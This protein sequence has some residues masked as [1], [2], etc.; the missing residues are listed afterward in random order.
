MTIPL[1]VLRLHAAHAFE[2]GGFDDGAQINTFYPAARML[3]PI[4]APTCEILPDT[5]ATSW[6]IAW[7]L[8]ENGLWQPR[9]AVRDGVLLTRKVA[10]HETGHAVVTA[11]LRKIRELQGEPLPG[12]RKRELEARFFLNRQFPATPDDAY[13]MVTQLGYSTGGWAYSPDEMMAESLSAATIAFVESE[14]TFSYGRD[15]AI[16]WWEPASSPTRYDPAG[17]GQRA[18]Q[19]WLNELEEVDMT[20]DEVRAIASD[21]AAGAVERYAAGVRETFG[22]VKDA[23]NDHRHTSVDAQQ[24]VHPGVVTTGTPLVQLGNE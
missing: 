20:P 8:G 18:R 3:F 14:W 16:R 21:V 1:E 19:F 13:G 12:Q 15:M 5:P 7:F 2:V 11:L 22:T 10:H 24:A 6:G 23:F 17:G 9:F 4:L